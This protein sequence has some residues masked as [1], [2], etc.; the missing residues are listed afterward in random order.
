MTLTNLFFRIGK[1]TAAIALMLLILIPSA[2]GQELY[3]LPLDNASSIGTTI[4]TDLHV[5]Q[6][7][8]SAIKISTLG[9]TTICLG[10]VQSLN[11]EN[12]QLVYRARVKSD[13]LEGAALLEMWCE[14]GG[15]R[16]F[17]RG[18]NSTVAGS[19]D[20]KTLEAPFFLQAGQKVE[21]VTL[22]IVISGKGTVWVDDIV[23]YKEPFN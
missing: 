1:T 2:G 21:R 3:R 6:E 5:K 15:G 18:V 14:V 4:S 19:M 22:N 20:W 11:V 12:A 9:P 17:S 23:L 10:T 16:Y 7:G 13:N 8:K